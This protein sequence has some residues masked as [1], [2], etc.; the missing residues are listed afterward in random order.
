MSYIRKIGRRKTKVYCYT[1][2]A[3]FATYRMIYLALAE[4]GQRYLT[5]FRER[6]QRKAD[7]NGK[8]LDDVLTEVPRLLLL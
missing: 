3:A 7:D 6:M 4:C 2:C 1:P 5:G 8:T